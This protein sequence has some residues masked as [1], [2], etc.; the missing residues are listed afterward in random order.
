MEPGKIGVKAPPGRVWQRGF[1]HRQ[2]CYFLARYSMPKTGNQ[3]WLV[4]GHAIIVALEDDPV[5][6]VAQP[7]KR[8]G[9][10]HSVGRE[11]V[12][13]LVEVQV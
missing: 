10:E 1:E 9:A 6:A 7:I 2:E 11:R 3:G 5:G 12:A 4:F 13:P 8:Y